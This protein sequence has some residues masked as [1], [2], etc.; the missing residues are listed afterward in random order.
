MKEALLNLIRSQLDEQ[1]ERLMNAAKE[2]RNAAT[3]PGSKAESKYDTR[4]IEASYLAAGQ[5]RQVEQL[6]QAIEIFQRITL[7]SYVGQSAAGPGALVEVVIQGE[8]TFF[9]L[10]AAAG[11]LEI[12]D[13]EK[14]ITLLSPESLL[15]Q[16]LLGC[17]PGQQLE[18]PVGRVKSIC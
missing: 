8:S 16:Q 5:A 18:R 17:G 15:Y 1:F 7:P 4:N 6:S 12:D 3:D 9:L 13:G 11:G 14:T 10:V 2:A